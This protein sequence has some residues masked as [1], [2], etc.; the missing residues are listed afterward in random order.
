MVVRCD[1]EVEKAWVFAGQS[2]APSPFHANYTF[3]ARL[4]LHFHPDK[5]VS[6]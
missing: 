1:G 4:R 3:Y 2:R 5:Q 6:R